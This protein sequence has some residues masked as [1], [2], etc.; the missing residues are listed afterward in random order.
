MSNWPLV[1]KVG[2][3]S[4]CGMSCGG[5]PLRAASTISSSETVIRTVQQDV[6]DELIGDLVLDLL[7]VFASETAAPLLASVLLQGGLVLLLEGLRPHHLAVDL[8]HDILAAGEQVLNLPVGHPSNERDGDDPEHRLRD[9][10]HRAHHT[11]P[12]PDE[13]GCEGA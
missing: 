5:G 6:V 7:L 8:E 11:L 2:S 4:T 10:A 12:T 13:S 3:C 1:W 9:F